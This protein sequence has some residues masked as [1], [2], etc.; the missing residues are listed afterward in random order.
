MDCK[1]FDKEP[2]TW[3]ELQ[4]M[5]GQLFA[6]L[7]CFV[8]VS[9]VVQLVRGEKEIDVYV[10]DRMSTP[11]SKYLCEC[12]F[13]GKPIHQEIVH[14][15]RTIVADCG[16]HRG[17]IIAKSGFQSGCHDAIKNTNIELISF[18]DLQGL[19]F[20]RWLQAMVKRYMPYADR[21]FPYWDPVGRVPKIKWAETEVEQLHLLN[22]AFSPLVRLGPG[23]TMTGFKREFPLTLPKVN[24]WFEV[25]G[26]TIIRTHREY[27]DFVEA[28]KDK[29][30]YR[31]QILFG[32]LE[33][34]AM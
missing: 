34:P 30:F 26:E 6:E 5:V 1:V 29:A 20:N 17:F 25:V 32:E 13:W 21:I 16:A 15:F 3:Q 27:F 18:D 4:N 23:D 31:Y 12:K 2:A 9:K 8:E 14:A 7:G 19:F 11:Y 24:D 33:R 28:E 22:A 10:E